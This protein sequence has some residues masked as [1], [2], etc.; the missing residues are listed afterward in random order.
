MLHSSKISQPFFSAPFS[1]QGSST[2]LGLKQYS[3]HEI[4]L[5]T[6]L[7]LSFVNY[8][9][10]FYK[11]LM[12]VTGKNFLLLSINVKN[13]IILLILFKHF[14]LFLSNFKRNMLNLHLYLL[15]VYYSCS[16]VS[17]CF[18][19]IK[20]TL[21]AANMFTTIL[22]IFVYPLLYLGYELHF[23]LKLNLQL[24]SSLIYICLVILVTN[25]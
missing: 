22:H 7:K 14:Y 4:D 9:V 1:S 20:N 5:G 3:L 6:V 16:F 11:Y 19:Y 21:L 23:C 10:K 18:I 17:F 15:L 24:Q 25:F 8:F 13:K 2:A 12:C